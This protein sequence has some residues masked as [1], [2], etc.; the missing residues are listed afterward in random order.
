MK[1]DITNIASFFLPFESIRCWDALY[2]LT[3]LNQYEKKNTKHNNEEIPTD[4]DNP[5]WILNNNLLFDLIPLY[6]PDA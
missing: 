2:C 5:A 1:Y 4:Q 3:F 6:C